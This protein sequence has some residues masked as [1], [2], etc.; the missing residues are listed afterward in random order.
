[1][2]LNYWRN[3]QWIL[4][5]IDEGSICWQHPEKM[6]KTMT[7]KVYNCI[8]VKL[9]S[10]FRERYK[11]NNLNFCYL[12][13]LFFNHYCSKSTVNFWYKLYNLKIRSLKLQTPNL[14]SFYSIKLL[15]TL[16]TILFSFSQINFK[17]SIFWYKF[18]SV[19]FLILGS[20]ILK[21][22]IL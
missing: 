16:K 13:T 21:L 10:F 17:L 7:T 9:L 20:N 11:I 14:Q 15:A 6:A 1:M 12:E 5:N 3:L 4:Q 19:K 8:L 18:L 22:H 2:F